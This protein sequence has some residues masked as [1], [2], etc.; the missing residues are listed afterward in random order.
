MQC[1]NRS[2]KIRVTRIGIVVLSFSFLV[3]HF[4]GG[5]ISVGFVKFSSAFVPLGNF[6]FPCYDSPTMPATSDTITMLAQNDGE[7][8]RSNLS[9]QINPVS[10]TG[11]LLFCWCFGCWYHDSLFTKVLPSLR[12]HFPTQQI[13]KVE[14]LSNSFPRSVPVP[15]RPFVQSLYCCRKK[16]NAVCGCGDIFEQAFERW[17][18]NG[19]TMAFFKPQMIVD[20]EMERLLLVFPLRFAS[21]RFDSIRFDFSTKEQTSNT[22]PRI[23]RGSTCW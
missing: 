12:G 3:P 5:K 20:L 9:I 18:A 8:A 16:Q 21:L 23:D 14:G 22:K 17:S 4:R 7:T 11:W 19:T 15:S 6:P 10:H 1:D 2:K 13:T